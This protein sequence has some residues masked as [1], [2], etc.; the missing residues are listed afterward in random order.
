[1][2]GRKG[3]LI[4]NTDQECLRG[5]RGGSS[6]AQDFSPL[7]EQRPISSGDAISQLPKALVA[8]MLGTWIIVFLGTA[9]VATANFAVTVRK[10]LELSET[11]AES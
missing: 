6:Y 8:E 3:Q 4:V 10:Q 5:L 7:V 1:M 9:A 11:G 2:A